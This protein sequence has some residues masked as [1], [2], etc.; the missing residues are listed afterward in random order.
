MAHSNVYGRYPWYIDGGIMCTLSLQG[1]NNPRSE[2]RSGFHGIG[3][4]MR[5]GNVTGGENHG[6]R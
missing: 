6:W 5:I 1:W 2:R 4:V 3:Y